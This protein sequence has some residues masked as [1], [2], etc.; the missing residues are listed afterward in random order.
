MPKAKAYEKNRADMKEDFQVL[1]GCSDEHEFI[2]G[3]L[4]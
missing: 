3:F 1:C 4:V 2:E